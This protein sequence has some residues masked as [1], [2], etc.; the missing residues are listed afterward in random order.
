MESMEVRSH[1]AIPSDG[2]VRDEAVATCNFTCTV[3]SLPGLHRSAQHLSQLV[4]DVRHGILYMF[5][6]ESAGTTAGAGAAHTFF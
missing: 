5:S 1:T 3:S 4:A 2:G 6:N